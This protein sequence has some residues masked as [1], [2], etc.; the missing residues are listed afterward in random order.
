VTDD[1][2]AIIEPTGETSVT[3]TKSSASPE[4]SAI[5]LTRNEAANIVD[6]L[7]SL[8]WA[9]RQIVVDCFSEDETVAL[10]R[11]W[12]AEVESITF[13]NFAQQRNAAIDATNT[14][15]IFFIDAD[16]RGTSDLGEEIHKSIRE[17]NKVA[18]YVPRHNYI[19]G[20]LTRGAGWYPDYQLRL[21]RHGSVRYERPVHEIAV[22]EGEI[23]Y[24]SKP[25]I[26][27]NYLD[28]DHFRE[29]QQFYT[30]YDAGILKG[31]GIHPKTHT[32]L[33]QP[34]RHFW[35]RFVTLKGYRD[36]IHGLRL[37]LLMGYYEWIKYRKLARMWQD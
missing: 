19:F 11:S 29:K 4:L 24:L 17:S 35:W 10:A 3:P 31:R 1:R 15:W 13:E 12:G 34:L 33:A 28:I 23:G 16:E 6:C 20:K 2:N 14:D 32:Y 27:Y 7:E 9:Q 18:W 25:M 8:T 26:H 5:I 21:F 37:S 36:G 30:G 22:V